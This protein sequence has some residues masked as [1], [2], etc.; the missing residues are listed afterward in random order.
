[1]QRLKYFEKENS[2][3]KVAEYD[4]DARGPGEV[5]GIAQSGMMNFKIATLQD[6]EI[7]KLASELSRGINFSKYTVLREKVREWEETVHLE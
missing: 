6:K 5:Y 7:I 4:L 2:G 1:M 3:F